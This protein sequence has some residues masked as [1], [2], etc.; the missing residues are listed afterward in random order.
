MAITEKLIN[1]KD[2]IAESFSLIKKD[3]SLLIPPVLSFIACIIVLP[4]LFFMVLLPAFTLGQGG[5]VLGV[6]I[7]LLV[8]Y[9]IPTFF[10]AALTCMVLEV[11]KGKDTRLKE[12]VQRAAKNVLDVFLFSVV[13]LVISLIASM[14]K[15]K[16]ESRGRDVAGDVV[17]GAWSLVGQLILPSM[18][19]TEHTFWSAWT[20]IKEYKQTI[21]Q[22]LAGSFGLGILFSIA[23]VIAGIITFFAFSINLM[24]GLIAVLG[25]IIPLILLSNTI[26]TIFFT[27]LYIQ[28][29][30]L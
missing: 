7:S 3:K 19:L 4:L 11:K 18:I 13:S 26:K 20:E 16:G 15:G 10:N 14:I 2:L 1:A 9:F 5:A 12:G 8:L 28:I 6:L 23:L 17:K 29:K 21:P 24:L 30:K 25:L 22:V 27:L